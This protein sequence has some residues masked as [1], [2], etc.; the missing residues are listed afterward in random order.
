MKMNI[1]KK[2]AKV[3]GARGGNSEFLMS[4]FLG[5]SLVYSPFIKRQLCNNLCSKLTI[6]LRNI[7]MA[8]YRYKVSIERGE[9]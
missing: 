4:G 7:R 5:C 6:A 9:R 2:I 1:N 3:C 8:V